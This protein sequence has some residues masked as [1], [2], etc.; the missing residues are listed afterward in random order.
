M[1]FCRQTVD[2]QRRAWL[3]QNQLYDVPNGATID[4]EGM[5]ALVGNLDSGVLFKEL[6]RIPHLFGCG[7]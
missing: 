2:R 4:I 6:E 3:V 5:P 1:A 7:I